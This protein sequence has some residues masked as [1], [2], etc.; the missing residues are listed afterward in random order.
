MNDREQVE[1]TADRIRDEL[2]LT[3]EELERRKERA[4]DVRFQFSRHRELFI[5]AAL[6]AFVLAGLGVGIATWRLRH[7]ARIR[8]RK[9]L[10]ALRRIWRHP[11]RLATS[12][13]QRSLAVE[14]GRRLIIIF[15]TALAT[16][17]AKDS[18]RTLLPRRSASVEG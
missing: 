18:V 11:E 16:T 4:L 13:E 6:A 8:A 14:M 7:R 12:N 10:R 15:G 17:L 3:L 1:H 5:G 2:L 9:R